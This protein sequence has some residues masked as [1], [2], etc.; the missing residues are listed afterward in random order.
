VYCTALYSTVIAKWSIGLSA[1]IA[2]SQ[3]TCDHATPDSMVSRP[4]LW[5]CSRSNAQNPLISTTVPS[6][7]AGDARDQ[8]DELQRIV[9]RTVTSSNSDGR[10]W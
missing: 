3:R 5:P 9:R 7:A 4:S 1:F 10:L 2:W 8:D 6:V